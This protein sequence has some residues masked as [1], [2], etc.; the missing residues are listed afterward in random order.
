MEHGCTIATIGGARGVLVVGGATGD[1]LVE[2]MDWE[3]QSQWVTLGKLNR[4]RGKNLKHWH[5]CSSIGNAVEKL[6]LLFII[7]TAVHHKHC[8]SALALLLSIGSAFQ[9]WHCS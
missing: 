2:F 6:A 9:H 8:C 3:D 7:S 4:G 5:C 1:D